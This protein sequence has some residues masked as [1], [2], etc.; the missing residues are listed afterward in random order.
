[1]FDVGETYSN[2][3]GNYTVLEIS[4]PTMTVRY[5]DGTTAELNMRIQKRI[6]ENILA[7]EEAKKGRKTRSKRKK[8]RINTRF[9]IK[10]IS[11]I[12]AEELA[13]PDWQERVDATGK[14][15]QILQQGD[16]LIFY[17]IES[18]SFFAVATITGG[19]FE[20]KKKD[21]FYDEK[22]ERQM[23]F[24]P[25]DIDTH[26]LDLENAVLLDS[27]ELESQPD[28]KKLVNVTG[29]Y[30]EINEDEF[31]LLSEILTEVAEEQEEEEEDDE[32]D[33]EFED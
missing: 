11:L 8:G 6:W 9:Y 16:R 22:A 28:F 32:E 21:P 20:P 24:F 26:A 2:R 25:V 14:Y 30:I 12:A 23:R 5:E 3:I 10:P 31:E 17:A 7:E 1:M 27:V 33:D 13:V 4:E 29:T 18:G 15:E 19:S